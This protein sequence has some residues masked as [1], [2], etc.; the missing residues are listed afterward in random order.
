MSEVEKIILGM[1]IIY[2]SAEL[3]WWV[4]HGKNPLRKKVLQNLYWL[5]FAFVLGAVPE[6]IDK[7]CGRQADFSFTCY[8]I[9]ATCIA[10]ERTLVLL[11]AVFGLG[12][13]FLFAG[14][15][16]LRFRSSL[17]HL[18]A[19]IRVNEEMENHYIRWLS[20]PYWTKL[21]ILFS[22]TLYCLSVTYYLY[23]IKYPKVFP[24][25]GGLT[26]NPFTIRK[27]IS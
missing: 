3:Y 14:P 5:F 12:G 10:L 2:L 24:C 22:I 16:Y 15:V 18:E 11:W 9:S 1:F 26:F 19:K 7:T 20:T 23:L 21:V 4:C 8:F 27:G 25:F 17:K 13:F 6:I